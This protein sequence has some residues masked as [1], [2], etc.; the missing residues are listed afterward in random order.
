MANIVAKCHK[1]LEA[2]ILRRSSQVVSVVG[3]RA[4]IFGGELRPREP[5]DNDVHAI[6]LGRSKLR[7]CGERQESL[8]ATTL[9]SLTII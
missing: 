4:Y 9:K 2:D 1:L 5:R 3:N 6:S 7:G 8:N